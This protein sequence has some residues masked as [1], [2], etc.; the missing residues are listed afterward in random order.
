MACRSFRRIWP[1]LELRVPPRL[2]PSR[3]PTLRLWSSGVRTL[4]LWSSGV[5]TL[6]LCASEFWWRFRSRHGRGFPRRRA[7]LE[8]PI[9]DIPLSFFQITKGI[10]GRDEVE[11]KKVIHRRSRFFPALTSYP[12]RIAQSKKRPAQAIRL[13]DHDRHRTPGR[14]V[15]GGDHAIVVRSTPCWREVDAKLRSLRSAGPSTKPK[16]FQGDR[17]RPNTRNGSHFRA[18]PE[19]RIHSAPAESQARTCLSR[20]FAFLGR[21]AA[22]SA[23]VRTGT[24]G[25]GR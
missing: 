3:L 15:Q 22:V 18:E 20:E 19:V 13:R 1:M 23:V 12:A 21:E 11:R 6:R 7:P 17:K 24:R 9:S 2:F 4:R 25:R 16:Q 8:P 10:A 14:A 5:R